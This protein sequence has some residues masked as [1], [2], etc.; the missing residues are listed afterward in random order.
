MT[1]MTAEMHDLYMQYRKHIG[2]YRLDSTPAGAPGAFRMKVNPN[3]LH[4]SDWREK[5]CNDLAD[6][7][8]IVLEK[9]PEHYDQNTWGEF[10]YETGCGSMHCLAGWQAG[11]AYKLYPTV[12]MEAK[13]FNWGSVSLYPGQEMGMSIMWMGWTLGLSPEE[14]ETLFGAE[15]ETSDLPRALRAIGAGDDPKDYNE[16]ESSD[17]DY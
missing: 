12:Y 14:A 9:V 16:Y 15:W 8:T 1:A 13:T 5:A 6:I 3:N 17:W 2:E 7:M 11:V 10:D 4:L